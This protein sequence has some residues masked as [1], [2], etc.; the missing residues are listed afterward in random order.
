MSTPKKD[1]PK[2][3][4]DTCV[5]LAFL[6]NEQS[7]ANSMAAMKGLAKRVDE[8]K[9]HLL[10]STLMRTEILASRNVPSVRRAFLDM[11]KSRHVTEVSVDPRIA[12]LASKIRSFYNMTGNTSSSGKVLC[13]PDSICLASAIHFE[14]DE[15]HSFDEGK[16]K[17]ESG[18]KS[19]GLLEIHGMVADEHQVTICKPGT[20]YGALFEQ[21]PKAK[22]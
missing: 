8:G 18:G 7:H 19:L 13:V 3:F 20:Q 11:L 21:L 10:V 1:L 22:A 14:A 6:K 17:V 16:K 12:E 4:W 15:L 9:A 5:M 2:Y